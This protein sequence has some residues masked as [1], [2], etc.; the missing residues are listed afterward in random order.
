M[1]LSKVLLLMMS[2]GVVS[3]FLWRAAWSLFVAG[4][5]AFWAC[6]A[7]LTVFVRTVPPLL[8]AA[9]AAA[10]GAWVVNNVPL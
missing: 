5:A 6:V 8:I 4:R 1:P 2:A 7:L 3:F 9:F 10:A